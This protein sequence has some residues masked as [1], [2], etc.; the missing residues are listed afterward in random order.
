M[1]Q[2]YL[3]PD[4]TRRIYSEWMH[5]GE[6]PHGF[7]LRVTK[8]QEDLNAA[9]PDKSFSPTFDMPTT[10]EQSV[11]V[12]IAWSNPTCYTFNP[13]KAGRIST[14]LAPLVFGPAPTA[15]ASTVKKEYEP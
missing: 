9:N 7:Y 3:T 5:A 10:P 8:A 6:T 15:P 14:L 12:L 4:E 1:T 13:E 2:R 11:Q